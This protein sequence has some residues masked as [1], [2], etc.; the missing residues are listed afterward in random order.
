MNNWKT[1][2]SKN[3]NE[4]KFVITPAPWSRH[5]QSH[6][7]QEDL[8]FNQERTRA[9]NILSDKKNLDKKLTKTKMCNS[10]INGTECKH[11]INCRFAHSRDELCMSDCLFG[12]RCKFV[13][14]YDGKIINSACH[15][16]CMH[17]HPMETKDQYCSRIGLIE[18]TSPKETTE[19]E[20]TD[21]EKITPKIIK[22]P[23]TKKFEV[24]ELTTPGVWIQKFQKHEKTIESVPRNDLYSFPNIVPDPQN[25]QVHQQPPQ[26]H[27]QPPQVHQ[28]PQDQPEEIVLRVPE[29]LAIQAME[30]A[31]NAGNKN[32][33]LELIN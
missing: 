6:E 19:Q 13:K 12:D 15:K 21:E 11:G 5:D 2:P 20:K 18:K 23:V 10:I 29:E 31:I 8:K 24:R 1:I 7:N 30:L 22:I 9:F 4:Q 16:T 25:T 17:I 27:Q 28:Q 32:I 26:V 14:I 3:I 33:K